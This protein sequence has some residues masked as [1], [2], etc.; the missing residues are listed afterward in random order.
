MGVY[1][2]ARS[3]LHVGGI[4][5]VVLGLGVLEV[6]YVLR[7]EVERVYILD[8]R[9]LSVDEDRLWNDTVGPLEKIVLSTTH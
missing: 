5:E 2:C 6:P 7:M 8:R 3:R 4:E 9:G 1:S